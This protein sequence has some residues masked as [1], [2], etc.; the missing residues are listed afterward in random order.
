MTLFSRPTCAPC[1]TLKHYL[2]RKG[3]TYIEKPAEGDEYALYAQKYGFTVPL[4]I[5]D[6]KAVVGLNMR[7]INELL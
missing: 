4:L 5:K 7:A 3:V 2:K 6:D 1:A